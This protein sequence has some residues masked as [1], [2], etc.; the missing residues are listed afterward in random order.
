[1]HRELL[2][3][4]LEGEDEEARQRVPL[5]EYVEPQFQ[6]R[7]MEVEYVREP[8]LPRLLEQGVVILW[9]EVA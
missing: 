8:R 6:L 7:D 3:Q 5:S 1:M 9:E 4:L 2:R